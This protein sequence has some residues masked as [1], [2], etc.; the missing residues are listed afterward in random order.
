MTHEVVRSQLGAT[1]LEAED[2]PL[3][4]AA[5]AAAGGP[6]LRYGTL[7]A[8]GW[9][10]ISANRCQTRGAAIWGIM[11]PLAGEG[12]AQV[13][14]A[15]QAMLDCISQGSGNVT[16]KEI[17]FGWC[18]WAAWD[19][20]SLAALQHEVGFD[21]A[22]VPGAFVFYLGTSGPV[23]L[24]KPAA[25]A[26]LRYDCG[27]RVLRLG[28]L[29]QGPGAVASKL[30]LV[31]ATQPN[32]HR[33]NVRVQA[34]TGPLEP[35]LKKT[36]YNDKDEMVIEFKKRLDTSSAATFEESVT[37]AAAFME[38]TYPAEWALGRTQDSLLKVARK[39]W[40]AER[41]IYQAQEIPIKMWALT[42]WQR[43]L[44]FRLARL[45]PRKRRLFWIVGAPS[46]GKG[47]ATEFLFSPAAWATEV[48]QN[49]PIAFQGC[50]EATYLIERIRDF[51][52]RYADASINGVPP[53]L[54]VLD[55]PKGTEFLAALISNIE[56]LTDVGQPLT[57]GKFKGA[58]PVLHSHVVVF[59][60]VEP[61]EKLLHRCIWRLKVDAIDSQPNWTFPGASEDALDAGS[62]AALASATV[63]LPEDLDLAPAGF[64]VPGPAPARCVVM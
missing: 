42:F 62:A 34:K 23:N 48:F 57:H 4:I 51:S 27:G 31:M 35:A 10:V 53:K 43:R 8:G 49:L 44:L 19:A 30:A 47:E 36:R 63:P 5:A 58:E 22:A 16:V 15:S 28:T 61:P 21:T 20:P 50:V 17:S 13:A 60:N 33:S 18:P 26:D 56:K 1:L 64:A 55:Y 40:D 39:V 59:S 6:A 25:A 11:E 46:T 3:V 14:T 41:P 32:D 45:G 29:A 7:A 24:R 12:V 38:L 9:G 37:R 2:A 54:I 52:M